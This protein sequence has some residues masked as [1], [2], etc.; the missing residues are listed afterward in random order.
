[1]ACMSAR[2]AGRGG[3]VA[4]HKV[5]FAAK[6]HGRIV[7]AEESEPV[8]RQAHQPVIGVAPEEIDAL[9][10]PWRTTAR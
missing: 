6:V 10:L 9:S 1:M 4:G 8:A 3:E 5:P 7:E 2:S